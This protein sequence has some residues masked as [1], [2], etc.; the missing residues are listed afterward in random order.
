MAGAAEEAASAGE[1]LKSA[2]VSLSLL[3]R[4]LSVIFFLAGL[5]A[6]SSG[7][8]PATSCSK[9]D[10]GPVEAAEELLLEAAI[11]GTNSKREGNVSAGPRGIREGAR[12]IKREQRGRTFHA[13][14]QLNREFWVIFAVLQE[15]VLEN[16]AVN[17]RQCLR[18]NINTND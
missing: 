8:W 2:V 12:S 17:L 6:E 13:F 11:A 5:A 16:H 1:A 18:D 4:G 10:A 14:G 9:V 7:F 15:N 3:S